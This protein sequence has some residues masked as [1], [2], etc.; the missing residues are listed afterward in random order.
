M[1][2]LGCALGSE[3]A[4]VAGEWA[5]TFLAC[6]LTHAPAHKGRRQR[7]RRAESLATVLRAP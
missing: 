6:A 4:S 2:G 1:S 7:L 3:R 5:G